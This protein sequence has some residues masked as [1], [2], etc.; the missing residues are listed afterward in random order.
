MSCSFSS[1]RFRRCITRTIAALCRDLQRS[2]ASNVWLVCGHGNMPGIVIQQ[3]GWVSYQSAAKQQGSSALQ[4]GKP[5]TAATE[6][7]APAGV[8][9][10]GCLGRAFIGQLL[11]PCSDAAAHDLAR[12][13]QPCILCMHSRR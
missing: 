8:V 2:S 5:N 11:L 7:A 9:C 3:Q 13:Q 4:A 10:W 1:T 6:Q 12:G